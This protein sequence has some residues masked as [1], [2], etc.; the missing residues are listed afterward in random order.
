M[1]RAGEGWRD[2]SERLRKQDQ[3]CQILKRSRVEK[4]ERSVREM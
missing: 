3:E 4:G 1:Q 2:S